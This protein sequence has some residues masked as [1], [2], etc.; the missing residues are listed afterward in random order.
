MPVNAEERGVCLDG[1][2]VK[3]SVIVGPERPEILQ[4]L[5]VNWKSK[6]RR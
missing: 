6:K 4:I 1:G 5:L 3:I 2:R